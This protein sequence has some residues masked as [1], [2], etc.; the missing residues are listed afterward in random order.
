MSNQLDQTLAQLAIS[1]PAASRVFQ[2]LGL[3]F[4]CQGRR[5]L[6]TACRDQAID[7]TAVLDQIIQADEPVRDFRDHTL[8]E[9]VDHVVTRYHEPACAELPDLIALAQRVE[10]RHARRPGCP[11]GLSALLVSQGQALVSHMNKEERV[12]FPLLLDGAGTRARMPVHVMQAEHHEHGAGLANIRRM[13]GNLVPPAHACTSWRA[14]YLRLAE[15]ERALMEHVA[16]EEE[17]LFPRG[18]A[19]GVE[20]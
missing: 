3:D 7:P 11:V 9:L 12:L 15:F 14:L 13:T 16:F 17:V 4:C 19:E 8:T 20:R 18:L 6:L 2:R 5:S 10:Q 1:H